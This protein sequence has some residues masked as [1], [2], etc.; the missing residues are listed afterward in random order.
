MTVATNRPRSSPDGTTRR[1]RV[2][3]IRGTER[4]RVPARWALQDRRSGYDRR[5]RYVLTGALH[6]NV[7]TLAV[8]LIIVNALSLLDFV[9]TF[10]AIK[11]G[12]AHEGNP[13]L[14]DL[15]R[16]SAGRAWIFKTGVMLAVSWGIW[17]ERRRRAVLATAVFSLA[18]YL[19]LTL[20]HLTGGFISRG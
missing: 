13:V 2:A 20:Y 5:K 1:L 10:D 4:R 8:V 15:F 3:A 6:D 16:E 7:L 12:I 17:R 11:L 14:A 9:L 19:A 18:A